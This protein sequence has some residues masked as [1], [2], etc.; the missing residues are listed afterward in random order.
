VTLGATA[1]RYF[2]P[3]GSLGESTE[4]VGKGHVFKSTDAGETWKDVSGNLPDVQATSVVVRDGQL[5]IGTSIGVF[6]S[7]NTNGGTYA[8]LGD[9]L[10]AVAI[11]SLQLKPGDPGTLMAATFGRGVWTYRFRNGGV[12]TTCATAKPFARFTRKSIRAA[13]HA[14]AGRRMTLR[15]TAKTRKGCGKIRKVQVSVEKRASHKRCRYMR[16]NGKFG[17]PSS[18][19]RPKF[20]AAKGRSKWRFTTRRK[21]RRGTYIVRARS[22]DTRGKASPTLRKRHTRITLRVH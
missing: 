5:V 13:R 20:I 16:S 11:Y 15:G 3:I 19:R 17:R 1:F 22:I 8:L 10:P 18:C 4:D 14:R 2:A 6:A 21:L 7:K 9:G 12:A